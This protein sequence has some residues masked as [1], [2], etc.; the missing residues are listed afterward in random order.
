MYPVLFKIGN[1]TIYTY[2]VFVFL[3]I[4]TGYIFVLKQAK[5]ERINE[6]IFS[7]IIFWS[8]IMGFI[9]ARIVYILV[10]FKNFLKNPF[11]FIFSRGGFVFY[12]GLIFGV[13]TFLILTKKYKQSFLKLADLVSMAIPLAHSIG[14]IGCFFNGCCYGKPTKAFWGIKFPPYT[15]AGAGGEKVI[16]TQLI[17]SFLLFLLFIFL[18]NFKKRKKFDGELFLLYLII[19]AIFRFFIEFLRG[20]ERGYIGIFSTSQFISL[21]ILFIA[22]PFYI[23]HRRYRPFFPRDEKNCNLTESFENDMSS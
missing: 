11:A 14:R 2:G 5:K 22:L 4:I 13:L 18:V 7:D 23:Y 21:I 10:E 17:S 16:P 15:L 9:G 12:G 3:A 6:K 8:I 20:D 19:Y 1:F